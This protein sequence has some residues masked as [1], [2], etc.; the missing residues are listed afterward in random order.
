MVLIEDIGQY[1]SRTISKIIIWEQ[2]V[3]LLGRVEKI[4]KSNNIELKST[5][6]IIESIES[7]E[8]NELVL[9]FDFHFYF[10]VLNE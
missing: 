10:F 4:I 6:N 3:L 5:R 8:S 2:K 7:N 9:L 1:W